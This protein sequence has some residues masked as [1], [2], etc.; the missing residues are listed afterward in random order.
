MQTIVT[1]QSKAFNTTESKEYFINPECYGDD[2]CKW[3]IGEFKTRGVTADTDPGQEDF[4][5]YFNFVLPEG[6]HCIVVGFRPTYDKDPETWI[7]FVE[8]DRNF[9]GSILGGRRRGIA[10]EAVK[11]LHDVLKDSDKIGLVLWHTPADFD[12]GREDRGTP[13]PK[14]D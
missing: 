13:E 9:L 7:A 2:V 11:L 14:D 8:R 1:F 3:L 4:G 12:Q 10:P 6:K 5:W